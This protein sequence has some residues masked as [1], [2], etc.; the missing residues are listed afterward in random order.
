[1]TVPVTATAPGADV[2]VKVAASMVA[3]FMAVPKVAVRA[4]FVATLGARLAGTVAMTVGGVGAGAVL[5][6]HA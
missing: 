1:M 5:N 3:G 6:T 2:S 4:E